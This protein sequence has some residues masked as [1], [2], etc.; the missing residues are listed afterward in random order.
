MSKKY[1]V[2]WSKN[3]LLGT[4]ISVCLYCFIVYL[5]AQHEALLPME[6]LLAVLIVIVVTITL[7]LVPVSIEVTDSTLAINGLVRT[8]RLPLD[9]VT[10]CGA[11]F[12]FIT[13]QVKRTGSFAGYIGK[14]KTPNGLEFFSYVMNK[15]QVFYVVLADGRKYLLSCKNPEEIVEQINAHLSAIGVPTDI[16]PIF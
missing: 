1:K 5:L 8:K 11:P 9:S 4:I 15:T 7:Y 6:I 3:T 14:Y 10:L 13:S 12:N 2:Q 16:K